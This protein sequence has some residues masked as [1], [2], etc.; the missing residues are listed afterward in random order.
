MTMTKNGICYDLDATQYIADYMGYEWHFSSEL[1][2]R[3]FLSKVQTKRDWLNDSL[4]RRFRMT[5]KADLL[6]ALQ[7]YRQVETRGFCVYSPEGV[8]LDAAS[9]FFE[10]VHRC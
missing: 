6:A 1:H 9:D 10:L 5:V 7:L 3:N 2:R 4:S 8:Q